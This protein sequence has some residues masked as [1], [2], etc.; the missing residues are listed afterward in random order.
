MRQNIDDRQVFLRQLDI[1]KPSQLNFPIT[2]IGVGGI[3]SWTALSL[4][5]MGCSN[6]TA[7]DYDKTEKH[8]APSQ[9]YSPQIEDLKVNSLKHIIH[10]LSGASITGVITSFQEYI[11]SKEYKAPTV[12]I[13]AVDS[14]LQRKE[15]WGQIVRSK[16]TLK[17][18]KLYIDARMGAELIRIYTINTQDFE[19]M[20]NYHNKLFSKIKPSGEKCTARAIAYN[21]LICAGLV[22]NI[23]KRFATKEKIRSEITLDIPSY[24]LI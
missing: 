8:N 13:S 7:I 20:E 22:T 19:Q 5:K 9:L 24:S 3:G 16:E 4:S 21:T 10:S 17:T 6:L 11:L 15:I 1:V 2:L 14:I 23:I 12:I 18:L